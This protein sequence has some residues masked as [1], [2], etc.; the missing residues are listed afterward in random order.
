M[1]AVANKKEVSLIPKLR[2]KEFEGEWFKSKL[3][4]LGDF[5]GGV[6]PSTDSTEYWTGD[7]PW[8]SCSDVFENDVTRLH[9]TRYITRKAVDESATKLVSKNS[10]LFVSRVGVG[11]L[12]INKE[13]LCTSQ[14]FANLSPSIDSNSYFIAYYF[15]A[16]NRLLHQFS[17]G[18]SIKVFTT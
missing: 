3:G 6:T 8:I 7:I 17:Q 16:K 18:T 1:E 13:E 15:I 12:A 9:I 10:I 14:D 2:F 11:K 4:K 5:K